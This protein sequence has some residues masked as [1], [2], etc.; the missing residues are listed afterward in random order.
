MNGPRSLSSGA[1]LAWSP[2]AFE[3]SLYMWIVDARESLIF[4]FFKILARW[5][6]F[7]A[8]ISCEEK[9]AWCSTCEANNVIV[10]CWDRFHFDHLSWGGQLLCNWAVTD[11]LGKR[12]WV[13]HSLLGISDELK[14]MSFLI[15][16]YM[17]RKTLHLPC[18]V[19]I[20]STTQ[21]VTSCMG[22]IPC[23]SLWLIPLLHFSKW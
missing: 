19:T 13:W 21:P 8:W 1:R 22:L 11:H 7:Y 6:K 3:W 18:F 5:L 10:N 14:N 4:F 23:T 2:C 20:Y 15:L 9:W 16:D 12:D 17:D